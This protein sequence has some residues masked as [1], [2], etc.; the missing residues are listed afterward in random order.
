MFKF[1]FQGIARGEKHIS[2]VY[3]MN[4]RHDR[5]LQLVQD[6]PCEEHGNGI[7]ETS[8]IPVYARLAVSVQFLPIFL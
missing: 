3:I 8:Y 7:P 1:H 4:N 2:V 6:V 5:F